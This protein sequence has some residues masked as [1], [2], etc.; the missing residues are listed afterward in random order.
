MI[1]SDEYLDHLVKQKLF[2]R[3]PIC[4]NCGCKEFLT[5]AHI[6]G[7]TNLTLRW[8]ILNLV[9]LCINCHNYF[10]V[11]PVKWDI[12][13]KTRYPER[14]EYLHERENI[15]FHGDRDLIYKYILSL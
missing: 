9:T 1:Y 15:I 3:M 6:I 4:M 13:W 10:E 14:V 5:P 11:D 2:E 7:R 8:D 12:W